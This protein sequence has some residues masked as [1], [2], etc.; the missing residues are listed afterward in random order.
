[1][2]KVNV[3]EFLASLCL[4]MGSIMNLV[5]LFVDVHRSISIIA[6]LLMGYDLPGI[7][8]FLYIILPIAGIDF[9]IFGLIEREE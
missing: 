6:T 4:L 8:E 9:S 7:F 2:N 5:E 1:M 3:V